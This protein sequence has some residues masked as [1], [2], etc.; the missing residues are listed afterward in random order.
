M[1]KNITTTIALTLSTALFAVPASATTS[2]VASAVI[3]MPSENNAVQPIRWKVRGR[4]LDGIGIGLG[5]GGLGALILE[6]Y[7]YDNGS[8]YSDYY[9][10]P[11]YQYY[12]YDDSRNGDDITY[13][14]RRFRS[15]DVVSGTYLGYDGR[16][17]NCP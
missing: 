1:L 4:H 11:R 12:D 2:L 7:N 8:S 17:H 15:Y 9:Y 13:C 16:R 6:R 3:T 5:I 10:E 14:Q